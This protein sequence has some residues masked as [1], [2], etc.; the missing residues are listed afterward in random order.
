MG[1]SCGPYCLGRNGLLSYVRPQ[2]INGTHCRW[3]TRV[4]VIQEK[5]GWSS[6]KKR[7]RKERMGWWR[8]ISLRPAATPGDPRRRPRNALR[9]RRRAAAFKTSTAFL[10][11]STSP[12]CFF[13]LRFHI[14]RHC[15]PTRVFHRRRCSS[16]FVASARNP[17]LGVLTFVYLLT[18]ETLAGALRGNRYY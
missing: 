8:R 17:E 12:T 9:E 11:R 16:F 1:V 14:F 2:A 3:R 7:K 5:N 18:T 15:S 10:V 13:F 4:A 6:K